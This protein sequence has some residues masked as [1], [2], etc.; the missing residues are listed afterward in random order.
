MPR[1]LPEATTNEES[2]Y[3]DGNGEGDK[4]SDG[5]DTEDSADSNFACEDE[6]GE[7]D[8]NDSVEPNSIDW[9]LCD[10]VDLLPDGGKREAVISGVSVCDSGSSNHATLTHTE[11]ADNGEGETGECDVL[12]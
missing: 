9:R 7:E 10:R 5:S 12:G 4:G 11:A 2:P 6:Q 8:A 3:S 1:A